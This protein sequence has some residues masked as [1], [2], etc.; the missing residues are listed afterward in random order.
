MFENQGGKGGAVSLLKKKLYA[1]KIAGGSVAKGQCSTSVLDVCLKIRVAKVA[2]RHCSKKRYM[3]EKSLVDQW[4]GSMQHQ[5]FIC[6][7]EN[8]GGKGGAA[9]LLKKKVYAKKIA[10][11]SVA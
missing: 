9:S 1:R 11:G 2:Q 4:H 5:C 3:L 7:F 8:Q 6:M 10:G